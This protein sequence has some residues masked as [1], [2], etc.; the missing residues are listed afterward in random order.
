[1]LR[2]GAPRRFADRA[3]GERSDVESICTELRESVAELGRN[4]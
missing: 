4:G 2:I 3:P 1:V